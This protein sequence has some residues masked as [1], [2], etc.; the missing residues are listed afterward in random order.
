MKWRRRRETGWEKET[1]RETSNE[2]WNNNRIIPAGSLKKKKNISCISE[3]R[4]GLCLKRS[5]NMHVCTY[6]DIM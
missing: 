6:G 5:A 4:S 3:V 2:R 1:E